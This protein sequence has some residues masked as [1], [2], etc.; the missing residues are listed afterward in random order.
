MNQL[1]TNCEVVKNQIIVTTAKPPQADYIRIFATQLKGMKVKEAAGILRY[2]NPDTGK[3]KK[4]GMTDLNYYIL[5]QYIKLSQDTN[6]TQQ[7]QRTVVA[8]VGTNIYKRQ[9]Q[10]QQHHNRNNRERN[11]KQPTKQRN[12]DARKSG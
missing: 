2:T 10:Q 8:K 9:Q 4:L 6:C 12:V 7:A 3:T 5:R 11:G 1:E